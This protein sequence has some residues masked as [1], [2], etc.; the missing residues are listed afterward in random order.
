MGDEV[1]V[2]RHR[3][4]T[5]LLQGSES[6]QNRRLEPA[7]MLVR[8][9]EINIRQRLGCR[10][11]I[12]VGY[13]GPRSATVEP[14]IKRVEAP[15]PSLSLVARGDKVL[16][17]SRPPVINA[18]LLQHSNNVVQGL[19]GEQRL[20]LRVEEGWN[21]D[22]P[23]TLPGNAPLGSGEHSR[24]ET[25]AAWDQI[26]SV[27]TSHSPFAG[28]KLIFSIASTADGLSVPTSANHCGVARTIMGF[29]VRQSMGYRCSIFSSARRTPADLSCSIINFEPAPKTYFPVR[30]EK[31]SLPDH[32]TS[33]SVKQP[34]SSTGQRKSSIGIF[35]AKN[36]S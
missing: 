28:T 19:D 24:R 16:V 15:S 23:A 14:N 11:K 17:W 1:P 21:R 31:A 3:L 35:W 27:T 22:S 7:T 33:S 34:S 30:A 20:A 8:T 13:Q 10:P 2:G 6:D 12:S 32:L 26:T 29:L 4:V 9:L 18:L 5:V 25:V 36:A